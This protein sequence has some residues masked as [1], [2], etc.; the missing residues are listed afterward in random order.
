MRVRR[1]GNQLVRRARSEGLLIERVDTEM[2]IYDLETKEAHCLKDLA[3]AVFE[4]SDGSRTLSAVTALVRERLG[5]S[6]GEPEVAA[7][8][9][10]LER[11]QLLEGAPLIDVSDAS[12]P[13]AV[14]RREAMRKFAYGGAVA[15]F[16]APLITSIAAP[17]TAW[18]V[19]G[20]P[21]GSTCTKNTDCASGHCCQNNPGK[22]CNVGCC[23]NDLNDCNCV[24]NT[25]TANVAGV[26][27]PPCSPCNSLC[28][29][30]GGVNCQC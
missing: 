5:E 8:V 30:G 24:N 27:N 20:C 7:A 1:T 11:A 22:N 9:E 4:H 28:T 14:S 17:A 18:A 25:C 23:V 26:I 16:A 2:V 3:A 6:I 29:A 10:Q 15:A 21:A 13:Q 12:S 19:S